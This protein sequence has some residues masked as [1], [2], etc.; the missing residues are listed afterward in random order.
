MCK[1]N[2]KGTPGVKKFSKKTPSVIKVGVA[3]HGTTRQKYTTR[4]EIETKFKFIFV[5]VSSVNN[6][7]SCRV[8]FVFKIRHEIDTIMSCLSCFLRLIMNYIK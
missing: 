7:T 8:V 6:T 5:F 3:I 2:Q 4:N 1:K